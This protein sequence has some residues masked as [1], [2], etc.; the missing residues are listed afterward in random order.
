MSK[1]TDTYVKRYLEKRSN[2]YLEM[3]CHYLVAEVRETQNLMHIS[4]TGLFS[5]LNISLIVLFSYLQVS[6]IV[7]FSHLQVSFH[8]YQ[9]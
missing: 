1:E 9:R 4:S 8:V 7:L 3:P 2:S 6:L 5:H